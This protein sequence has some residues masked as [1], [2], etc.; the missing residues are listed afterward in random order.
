M[1]HISQIK[2]LPISEL[3]DE[4]IAKAAMHRVDAIG[5]IVTYIYKDEC[6]TFYRWRNGLA[7]HYIM[8]MRKAW[9]SFYGKMKDISE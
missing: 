2:D 3:T 6:N 9:D 4:E 8:L 7:R 5:I 1:R